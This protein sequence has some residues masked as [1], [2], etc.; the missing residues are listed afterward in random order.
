MTFVRHLSIYY[1]YSPERTRAINLGLECYC[2]NVQ[3]CDQCGSLIIKGLFGFFNEFPLEWI[4][5]ISVNGKEIWEQYRV[6]E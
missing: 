1:H 6:K 5:V 3:I 4:E 2:V